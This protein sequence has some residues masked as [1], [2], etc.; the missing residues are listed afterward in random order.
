MQTSFLKSNHLCAN[1][2]CHK[3]ML[4]RYEVKKFSPEHNQEMGF[5]PA[6]AVAHPDF[7]IKSLMREEVVVIPR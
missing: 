4:R 6:C 1:K 3:P 2:H 7:G 5:H